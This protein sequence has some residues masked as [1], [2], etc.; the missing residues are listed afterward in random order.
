[1]FCF[2]FCRLQFMTPSIKKYVYNSRCSVLQH[3]GKNDFAQKRK[4]IEGIFMKII[5]S[6]F[7][8]LTADICIVLFIDNCCVI[9]F[10]VIHKYLV[11]F[12]TS[13]DSIMQCPPTVIVILIF[14]IED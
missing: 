14:V 4:A 7:V 3:R 1:M 10:R 9:N 6:A 12:Q 2:V 8:Q 13:G 5:K 11:T